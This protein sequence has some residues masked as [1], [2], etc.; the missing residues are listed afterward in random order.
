MAGGKMVKTVAPGKMHAGVNLIDSLG[1][2]FRI[3]KE[4]Y[5]TFGAGQFL[6]T[7][8]TAKTFTLDLE[9]FNYLLPI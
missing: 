1:D 6:Q 3:L 8:S 2:L 5:L 9:L 4:V 7:K